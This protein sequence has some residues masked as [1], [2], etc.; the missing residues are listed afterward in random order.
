V[1]WLRRR[2]TGLRPIASLA[3]P[4][5]ATAGRDRLA[6]LVAAVV[7]VCIA[8][9]LFNAAYWPFYEDD[10]I[11]LYAPIARHFAQTGQF[12]NYGMHDAYPV[13]DPLALAYIQLADPGET[14]YEYAGRFAIAALALAQIGAAYV[15]GRDLFG[16]RAGLAAAYLLATIPVLLH[17]AS[18]GYTDVPAGTYS[19]LAMIMAWRLFRT[20]HP[21]Y[22]L[23]AGVLGGLAAF[24]K[25][26]ALLMAGSLAG[27]VIYAWWYARRADDPDGQAIRWQHSA[28]MVGGW[29]AVAGIW[30][31]HALLQFGYLIPPTGWTDQAQHTIAALFGPALTPNQFMLGGAIPLLGMAGMLVLL[32]RARWAFDPRAA[33]LLGFG[34]PFWLVWWALFSYDMRFLLLVWGVFAVAGGWLVDVALRWLQDQITNRRV[35]QIGGIALAVIVIAAALPG[36]RLAVD[37]KPAILAD[38]LMDDASRHR[39]QFGP[40]WEAIAWLQANAPAG[41]RVAVADYFFGY[42]LVRADITIAL[43][44]PPDRESAADYDYWV[45]RPQDDRPDWADAGL[46][47]VFATDAGYTIYVIRP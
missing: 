14:A 20:P 26:G 16:R 3:R 18:T 13:L 40:R 32:W 35:Q 11:T 44:I 17:W 25:N 8:A 23:L 21:V 42:P 5:R 19:L 9:A 27:W 39:V 2:G 12:F 10:T 41:S 22:A 6:L 37:H 24:T 31:A 47:E 7:V 46:R 33:L 43:F 15:L 28:L 36:L 29:L 38:P 1:I 34:V 45:A 4:Y 30:Y